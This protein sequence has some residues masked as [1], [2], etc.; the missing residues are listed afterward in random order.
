MKF[1]VKLAAG[2]LATAAAVWLVPGITLQ[3]TTTSDAAWTLLLVTAVLAVINAVVRPFAKFLSFCL[4]VITFGAFIL[5]IN[6]LMLMLTSWVCGEI[7]LGFHVDGFWPAL[8]GSIIISI[9]T[10]T[11]N[12][13]LARRKRSHRRTW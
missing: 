12:A 8:L 6:A 4:L 1:L 10:T 13:M 7:G 11:V 2:A 3:T 5:V 9:I